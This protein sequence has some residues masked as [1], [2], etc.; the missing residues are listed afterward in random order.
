MTMSN[1]DHDRTF[2][3]VDPDGQDAS[4][5]TL[6]GRRPVERPVEPPEPLP[7]TIGEYRILRVLG[8]GG[9]GIVYEAEQLH[10]RRRV[11]LKV[12]RG[13]HEVDAIHLRLFQRETETLA[14]L[15]HPG[16][17]AIYESGHTDDGRDFFAMELVSGQTLGQ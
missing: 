15:K 1:D 11:A 14:R 12:M 10:P 9:M 8:R 13:G 6:S 3:C 17:A 4:L 2:D 7:E 5:D 16:I